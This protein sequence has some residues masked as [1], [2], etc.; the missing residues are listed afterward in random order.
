M[1]NDDSSPGLFDSDLPGPEYSAEQASELARIDDLIA[2]LEALEARGLVTAE[3]VAT[4][5][6]EKGSRRRALEQ[7]G[8]ASAALRLAR[9]DMGRDPARARG[10]AEQACRLD[11]S[12]LEC[13]AM[14]ID[15]ARRLGDFDRAL[16]L[17]EEGTERHGHAGLQGLRD[18]IADEASRRDRARS[19]REALDEARTALGAGQYDGAI[20]AARRALADDPDLGLASEVLAEACERT[21]RIEE[22]VEALET[23]RLRGTPPLPPHLASRLAAMK[24]QLS[25]SVAPAMAFVEPFV[26]KPAAP[27]GPGLRAIAAEFLQDH[28][29][30]LLLGLAVALIVVSSTVGAAIVLG[31]RL[32][33]PEGKCLLALAYTGLFAAFGRGLIR[34]GAERAGR[35]MGMTTLLVMPLN[36]ALLGELPARGSASGLSVLA[37]GVAAL[38]L[39]G[40]WL[41]RAL[42]LPGGLPA[43]AGML[44][45]GLIDATT[46]RPSPMAWGYPAI[47]LASAVF[48]A[49]VE[50]LRRIRERLPVEALGLLAFAFAWAVVRIGG[51]VGSFPAALYA[52]PAMLAGIGAVRIVS[53]LRGKA[54][55]AV[56][57]AGLVMA[58]LAFAIALARPPGA[59]AL[60]SGNTL[61]VALLGL[62]LF[63]RCLARE[64]HPAYLYAAFGALFLP[65][66]GSYD[67]LRDLIRSVEGAAAQA[68]GYGNRLPFAYKALNGLVFNAALL[69]LS[70]WFD[71]RWQDR[72]L[73]RHCHFIGLPVAATACILGSTEPTAALLTLSGYAIGFAISSWMLS[74][75][76]LV[77][78][79]CSAFAG[80]SLAAFHLVGDPTGGWRSL[81]MASVSMAYWLACRVLSGRGV[82]EEY[83]R[84]IVLS[85]RVV[86]GLAVALA[87][88]AMAWMGA[89]S[90]TVVAAFAVLAV[91]Y[92]LWHEES[93][94]PSMA[95]AALACGSI[96]VLLAALVGADWI[97]RPIGMAGFLAWASILGAALT[98]A[99]GYGRPA[100]YVQPALRTGLIVLA[101]SAFLALSRAAD[102]PLTTVEW[103]LVAL[104][105]SVISIALGELG[106][107]RPGEKPWPFLSL[108]A[109]WMAALAACSAWARPVPGSFGWL[110]LT[111]AFVAIAW[112]ALRIALA[113][114][115]RAGARAWHRPLRVMELVGTLS[116]IALAIAARADSASAF[117]LALAS[118]ALLAPGLAVSAWRERCP[119][120]ASLAIGSGVLASVFLMIGSRPEWPPLRSFGV[121]ATG[122]SL[123][124]WALERLVANRLDSRWRPVFGVPLLASAVLL[125]AFAPACEWYAPAALLFAALPF[126]LFVASTRRAGWLYVAL[127][128][129]A[130]SAVFHDRGEGYLIA[131]LVLLALGYVLMGSLILGSGAFL[132]GLAPRRH[133]SR[134]AFDW[135]V[136]LGLLA[137]CG[138]VAAIYEGGGPWS[139]RAWLPFAAGLLVL[140]M[141]LARP[142]RAWIH[143]FIGLWTVGL[144]FACGPKLGDPIDLAGV[145]LVGSLAA[146]IWR[147]ASWGAS[148]WPALPILEGQRLEREFKGWSAALAVLSAIPLACWT[149]AEV[150][151]ACWGTATG[152]PSGGTWISGLLALVIL[153]GLVEFDLEFE[154][155]HRA[156]LGLL[157]GTLLLWWL[158]LPGSPLTQRLAADPAA[159]L[160]L[161]TAIQALW[162]SAWDGRSRRRGGPEGEALGFSAGLGAVVAIL[163]TGG[164]IGWPTSI[165]LAMAT[166]VLAHRALAGQSAGFAGLAGLSGMLACGAISLQVAR[167]LGYGPYPGSAAGLAIG[168][169]AAAAGLVFLGDRSPASIRRVLDRFGLLACGTSAMLVVSTFVAWSFP[170]GLAWIDMLL[171]AGVGAILSFLA[172]RRGSITL[173]ALAQGS[174]LLGY[175]A[176]RRGFPEPG[177]G[178]STVLLVLATIELGLAEALNRSGRRHFGLPAFGAATILPVIGVVLAARDGVTGD[179]AM[180]AACASA[181]FY[182]IVWGRTGRRPFGQASAVL[183]N[184]FLWIFWYRAGWSFADNPQCY[185]IP[186][187]LAA[188]LFAEAYRG[189]LGKKA[190]SAI[191]GIGLA[192]IYASLALPIWKDAS[193]G[194]WALLLAGSMLAIFAGIGLRS[195]VFLWMGLAGFILNVGYQVGRVGLDHALAR[196]GIMLALGMALVLFVALSEKQGWLARMKG[197]LD[198]VR[199]WD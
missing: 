90:W 120:R 115:D 132:E 15:L 32:W 160:P 101:G 131:S 39:M 194:A 89:A 21:G 58:G 189:E 147:L 35:I 40:L 173:A 92:A 4:V 148:R 174:A 12:R 9:Q 129:V 124:C 141:R 198:E 192:L 114:L 45:I 187:G 66:F 162:R 75:P 164:E 94:R 59:S 19:A 88:G 154:A 196:W 36:F 63:G 107:R 128:L 20:R 91:L 99:S 172:E 190:V 50:W 110:A 49:S 56:R 123:A 181:A 195:Q 43:I 74:V 84:P 193:L 61:A 105:S 150:G 68:L 7:A 163:L 136:I 137:L 23:R 48:L 178:D 159:A 11:P 184:A 98:M 145:V 183:F 140:S 22:A 13:W 135:A 156:P 146:L 149:F 121:L 70:R 106:W 85:A 62:G 167:A 133:L 87:F 64:R 67:F 155:R 95:Y 169:L 151:L 185:A 65:Y 60:F 2:E 139:S 31:D 57:F 26:P 108:I 152:W 126:V 122:L 179:R 143:G 29:Q 41:G 182:A 51:T 171:L 6:A 27:T 54:E 55:S 118:A 109:C 112:L 77:Y 188:F 86:S 113:G 72:R 158:A 10:R 76:W 97:G 153:A 199:G 161:L 176:Y 157:A 165:T 24:R 125:A 100:S 33:R 52:V 16:E 28:W 82:G 127:G 166:A 30:K 180:F 34:W 73:A 78:L 79:A 46:P 80:A 175:L 25:P 191:R 104:A 81:S 116:A 117:P 197:Y 186:V 3:A 38:S 44:A 53:G 111:T 17:C 144:L 71:R 142:G 177:L 83:R 69:G 5:E 42:R 18:A 47:L 119:G 1:A 102:A 130:T 138:Q 103:L 14:A 93:P 96:S 170:A 134:P 168:Q 37:F 8:R